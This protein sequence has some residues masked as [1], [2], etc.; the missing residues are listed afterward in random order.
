LGYDATDRLTILANYSIEQ[1]VLPVDSYLTDIQIL[2]KE[3]RYSTEYLWKGNPDYCMDY[4]EISS[5]LTGLKTLSENNKPS[6]KLLLKYQIK[7]EHYSDGSIFG[8]FQHVGYFTYGV[9]RMK[10]EIIEE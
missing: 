4:Y 2:R 6:G 5:R 10:Q 1:P 3:A 8:V 9:W 7:E